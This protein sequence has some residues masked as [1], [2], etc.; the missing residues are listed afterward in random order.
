MGPFGELLAGCRKLGMDVIAR[1][2]PHAC[3]V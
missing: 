1:T 2:D 3:T